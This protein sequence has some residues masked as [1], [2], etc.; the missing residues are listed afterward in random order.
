ME[1]V[2]DI[3]LAAGAFGAAA[4]CYVLS[5]RLAKFKNLENGMGGAV[6]V[7]SVQVDE[8]TRA[9]EKAQTTSQGSTEALEDVTRRAENAANRME[10]LLASLHDLSD[11][12]NE[13][14]RTKGHKSVSRRR[15]NSGAM[16]G[17]RHDAEA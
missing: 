3:L 9:L 10:L 11:Q 1:L 4:Y 17:G 7:M 5:R 15:R 12:R 16:D 14:A 13:P 6:A 8:L 2:A